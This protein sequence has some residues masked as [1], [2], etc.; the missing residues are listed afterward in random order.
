MASQEQALPAVA[1]H[2]TLDDASV[3]FWQFLKTELAPYPGRAWVVGRMTVAA[4]IT[5]ILVMT[6]RIPYGFLGAIYTLFLSRESPTVT[7]RSGIR[8]TV[9]YVIATIYTVVGVMTMVGSPITHFLWIAI[10]LFLAFYLIHIMPDYFTAVGFGFL[11]AGAIPLWDETYLTVNQRTENTLWLGASVVLGSAV[12]VA[13]EYIFRRVHPMT[14]LTQGIEN[15]LGAVEDI[16]RQIAADLPLGDKLE[17]EISLYSALGTSRM[18][19]QLLRS[20]FPPQLVA[21]MNVA[22]ALLGRLT[23][24]AASMRI[25]RSTQ[26]I[27]LGAA[28]RER[29]LRLANQISG[30]R[31][32]LQQSKLPRTIEL[33]SQAEPSELPL[34]PEMERTV[35]LI[36]HAFS[37]SESV[38][39][40]FLPPPVET[41]IRQRLLLHDAFSNPDHLKFAVRG[42]AATMLAYVVYQAIDWTGLSTA[43]PTCIITALSTIGSS[44][45]KQFLRLG[46]AIIGGFVFGMGAQVFV[47]PYLDGITGF[48]VL[49]AVVTAISAWIAVATPRLSYLGVQLALAFYLIN[50]QE[51]AIQSSL[52]IARDRVVGVLLGLFCMWLVFDRLWV[53]DA[54]QEMQEGFA[55]NLRLLAE[56]IEQAQVQDRQEAVRQAAQL[57][58]QINEGFN[59]VKAQADAVVFEF[60]PSRQRKLKIRDDFRRWQPT[61]GT[62]L[63]VQITGLQYLFEKRYPELS[64][65]IA[66][67]L[68]AFENDM[69]TTARAMSDEVAGKV[70]QA[71][72]DV[73]ESA[74]RLRQEIEKHYTASGLPVPPT[75]VDMVTISQNLAS[76]IGP[77]Y[78]DIHSTFANPQRAAMHYPVLTEKPIWS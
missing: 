43:V 30:L 70:A 77:L 12:T 52:A 29:C 53:R 16:L 11:L 65:P 44:R 24:L 63:Q 38:E 40:M 45:Q 3:W 20:G 35:A 41:E 6:F 13:V 10:S 32:D 75:L 48:T 26:S 2:K 21:Q 28:D 27:A 56:V 78:A 22:V 4:T 73:Q 66:D 64:Q 61:L 72:P 18:R 33:S 46:G 1:Q 9:I 76:I 31:S 51:F 39:D 37:G 74:A 25:V 7:L 55:R 69:A 50:L 17:K 34:L 68:T 54:L 42:A 49:F 47:L 36:P 67:A 71:A 59:A 15:R 14:E 62:L 23:D 19:R 58:D 57:R 60:G 8:V 5:M